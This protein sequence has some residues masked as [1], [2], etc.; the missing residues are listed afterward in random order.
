MGHAKLEMLVDYYLGDPRRRQRRAI[1][2]A[3]REE[4]RPLEWRGLS[5]FCGVPIYL[6]GGGT[7]HV[8][9]SDTLP[10]A[11]TA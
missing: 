4:Q 9:G 11:S 6:G 5:V 1:S 10:D 7:K 2:R 3:E 8:I